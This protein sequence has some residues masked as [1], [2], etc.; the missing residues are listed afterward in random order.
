MGCPYTT[1]A[2]EDFVVVYNDRGTAIHFERVHPAPPR[3]EVLMAAALVVSTLHEIFVAPQH[4]EPRPS[5]PLRRVPGEC[6]PHSAYAG[7]SNYHA[8]VRTP[9]WGARAEPLTKYLRR[10]PG[11]RIA[12]GAVGRP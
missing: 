11:E 1:E 10:P 6:L 7:I 5:P 9:D 2:V 3:V 4:P 8:P 12:L